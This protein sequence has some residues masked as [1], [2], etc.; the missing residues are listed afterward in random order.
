MT[1]LPVGSVVGVGAGAI[2]IAKSP[3]LAASATIGV[4]RSGLSESL[5]FFAPLFPCRGAP[6]FFSCLYCIYDNSSTQGAIGLAQKDFIYTIGGMHRTHAET[7]AETAARNPA[8]SATAKPSGKP[9][10][11]QPSGLDCRC[12][13]GSGTG[14]QK[15]P[16]ASPSGTSGKR[17]NRTQSAQTAPYARL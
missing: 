8:H 13:H 12:P 17:G 3:C 4:I 16:S 7:Q 6:G 2:I 1:V 10:G 9:T 15:Q 5:V 11:R 14:C